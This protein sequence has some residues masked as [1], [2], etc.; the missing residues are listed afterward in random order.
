MIRN[1]TTARYDDSIHTSENT[2]VRLM[3]AQPDKLSK[4]LIYKWGKDS[5]KFPL[6]VLTEGQE[7][8]AS[9]N[10]V[11]SIEYTLD[12]MGRIT[13]TD[14]LV[15]AEYAPTVTVGKGYTPF[16]IYAK[17]N[18]FTRDFGLIAADGVTMARIMTEGVEVPGR[19]WR[20]VCELKATTAEEGMSAELLQPGKIWVMTAPTVAEQLSRG[21]KTSVIGPSKLANQLSIQRYTKAI[22]GNHANKV[23]DIE[24]EDENGNPTNFWI[25]EE[26]RQFDVSL[27][28]MNEE[29]L[30]LSKY[31]RTADGSI[32]MK[33]YASGEKVPEGA[34][35]MEQVKEQ[36]YDT[37]GERLTLGKIKNMMTVLSDQKPDNGTLELVMYGGD[38]F[39]DDFDYA[40]KADI[41]A[42]G[43]T[44][45]MGE[46]MISGTEGALAYGNNFTQYRDV[47]GNTITIKPLALFNNGSVAEVQKRNG[48]VHPRTRK[49]MIS[50]TGILLDHSVYDG[51]RNIKMAY[52]KGR[53]ELVGVYKGITPIP[54]SWGVAADLL[55]QLSTDVDKASYEKLFTKGI[56]IAN[57]ANC[58]MLQSVL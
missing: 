10:P 57:T 8:N 29:H 31:N 23:V 32:M 16:N 39:L 55:P 37:Y 27:Y 42:S 38:G 22:A 15:Y 13:H 58:F 9:E 24:F 49:P 34:G 2:L 51:E 44:V 36:N 19:G 18:K 53:K 25:N 6:T 43:F 7:G 30:W 26:M 52:Q 50:H 12:I 17:T 5:D 11:N 47:K 40:I 4:R 35:V 54:P 28:Q 45:A 56:D 20:F 21:N 3:L 1:V 41:A 46:K 14:E 48:I 33:D